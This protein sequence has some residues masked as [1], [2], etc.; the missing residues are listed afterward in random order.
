MAREVKTIGA[1]L[2][3]TNKPL[4]QIGDGLEN[5]VAGLGGSRDKRSYNQYSFVTPLDRVTLENMYRGSW[6]AKR[7]VNSVADDM[8][9]E[10]L[11]VKFDDPSGKHTMTIEKAEKKFAVRAKIREALYWARLY[12]GGLVIIGTADKDLSKPLRVDAIRQGGLRYL[13]VVDRW[14][15]SAGAEFCK[16]LTSPNFGKPEYYVLAESSVRIHHTRILRFNGQKLPYFAWQANGYWDDSELQ[17]V[18][19]SLMNCDQTTSSIATMLFEANV[20]I[21]KSEQLADLL[22]TKDGESK[23]TK[24]FQLA[25]MMKSFNRMLLLDSTETFEKKQNAFTNLDK[26]LE[27]FMIDVCGAADIPMTRLFGQSPGGL[28]ST[29]DGDIRNYYDMVS[30][31]QEAEMRPQL[32]YLYEILCRSE[33]GATPDDFDFD[34]NPLWQISATEKSSIQKNEA[35]RDK[36]YLEAGVI[37]EVMVAKE[38]KERGTYPNMTDEDIKLI[39]ELNE[40][41]EPGDPGEGKPPAPGENASPAVPGQSQGQTQGQGKGQI[42]GV[43]QEEK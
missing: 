10:W 6:L 29:G 15:V 30:S 7:I 42:A 37:T 34:F 22:S 16:D 31:K 41:L 13:H 32:E 4:K 21:I 28:N 19:D 2:S 17:H 5:V 20:D 33:I 25:A 9:R 12:G 18:Y 11:Q 23:V 1:A 38:L 24:R 40:P 39:E 3:R 27:K 43:A 36:V 8:T 14:R 35:D 26:I